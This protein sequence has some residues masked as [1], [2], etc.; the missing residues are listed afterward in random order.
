MNITEADVKAELL[1]CEQGFDLNYPLAFVSTGMGI[2]Y[3]TTEKSADGSPRYT[4]NPNAKGTYWIKNFI[5]DGKDSY[6]AVNTLNELYLVM[7]VS[8]MKKKVL[9]DKEEKQN[10][11]RSLVN[12]W[13]AESGRWEIASKQASESASRLVKINKELF[14]LSQS[15]G[16]SMTDLNLNL[17]TIS[18]S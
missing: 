6:T 7:K 8:I 18:E 16:I 1:H 17:K 15:M 11:L 9:S 4:Q 10:K 2:S 13:R 3:Q 12:E 14:E 5:T